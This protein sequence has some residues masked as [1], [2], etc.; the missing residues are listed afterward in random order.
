MTAR[1]PRIARRA[2]LAL[3]TAAIALAATMNWNTVITQTPAGGHRLGR[4]DQDGMAHPGDLEQGHGDKTLEECGATMH[5]CPARLKRGASGAAGNR[6][7]RPATDVDR[8]CGRADYPWL[9][10]NSNAQ[11]VAPRASRRS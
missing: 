4:G 3:C 2:A 9:S 10:S 11:E 6:D 1:L 7:K 8:L 5:I